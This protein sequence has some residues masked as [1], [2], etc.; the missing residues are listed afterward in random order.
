MRKRRYEIKL[1]L[2]AEELAELN[3]KVRSTRLSREAFCRSAILGKEIRQAPPVDAAHLVRALRQ[4]CASLDQ[5]LKLA[6][7]THG[8]DAPQV[9]AALEQ[10]TLA[11]TAV[12]N[13]YAAKL[14]GKRET[15]H[16][17]YEPG[18]NGQ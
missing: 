15:N 5:L 6:R 7:S 13:A 1:R 11:S 18:G 16:V 10:T 9:R 8:I 4:A 12:V 14:P 2:T 17:R 3:E